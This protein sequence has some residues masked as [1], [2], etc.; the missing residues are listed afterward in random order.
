MRNNP[1]A[2]ADRVG[3]AMD[4]AIAAKIRKN[5]ALIDMARQNLARWRQQNGGE[6]SP[7]H[8]EWERVLRFLSPEQIA[9]F[10]V[11]RTPMA[12]RLSQSSPFAGILDEGER[13]RILGEHAAV[14][15]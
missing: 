1:H 15:A 8:Q 10:L 14:A 7:A 13:S 4:M 2:Y 9:E 11:S 5:P 3:L 12:A 6:L